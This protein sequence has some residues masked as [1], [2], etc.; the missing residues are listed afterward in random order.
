MLGFLVELGRFAVHLC[1]EDLVQSSV[2]FKK[3]YK[4]NIVVAA[5]QKSERTV[6]IALSMEFRKK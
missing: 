2:L 1:A 3:A 5:Y 6:P 4:S